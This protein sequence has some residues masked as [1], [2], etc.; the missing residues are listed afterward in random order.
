M[1]INI[2][3]QQIILSRLEN[4]ESIDDLV[5]VNGFE[6]ELK[7]L[8]DFGYVECPVKPNSKES[9]YSTYRITSLGRSMII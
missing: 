9:Y 6:K 7:Y 2:E 1:S 8:E 4:G 5:Q 3:I